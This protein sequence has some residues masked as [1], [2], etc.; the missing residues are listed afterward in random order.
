MRGLSSPGRAAPSSGEML[1]LG[2]LRG[3]RMALSGPAG[4]TGEASNS[5]RAMNTSAP[6]RRSS[7]GQ[8]LAEDAAGALEEALL[9]QV[10]EQLRQRAAVPVDLAA[11][12]R[13]L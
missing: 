10:R 6:R 2:K 12:R 9:H 4:N 11:Q 3:H 8:P 1:N 13:V 7:Q 5:F